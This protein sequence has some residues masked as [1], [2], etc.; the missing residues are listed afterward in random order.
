MTMIRSKNWIQQKHVVDLRG[1]QGNAMVLLGLIHRALKDS[2]LP[3]RTVNEVMKRYTKLSY[4]QLVHTVDE[5]F[6]DTVI[7]VLPDNWDKDNK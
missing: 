3:A 5:M 4:R 6:N 2:K 1:P 7:L